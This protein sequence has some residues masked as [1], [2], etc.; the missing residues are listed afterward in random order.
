MTHSI[1]SKKLLSPHADNEISDENGLKLV[2]ETIDSIIG[3]YNSTVKSLEESDE[4][5][6]S[7]V[8]DDPLV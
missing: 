5:Y 3:E 7:I 4:N 6:D 8:E 2:L 1:D